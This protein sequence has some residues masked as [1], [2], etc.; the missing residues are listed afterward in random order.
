MPIADIFCYTLL[1]NH[2]HLLV[3]IKRLE[4]IKILFETSKPGILQKKYDEN[5]SLFISEQFANWCNSYT[6]SFN[7]LY[8]R[9]G[10][11]FMDNLNRR[12]I[13]SEPYYSKMVHYIHANTVQHRLTKT[14]A[15]WPYH[16]YHALVNKSDGDTKFCQCKEEL[17]DWFGGVE[18]FIKFHTQAIVIKE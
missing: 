18:G 17:L 16:S 13:D 14:I 8:G 2:F 1:P 9:K 4:T 7:R 15:E 6:K 3:R 5:L 11:L 12:I 10:K